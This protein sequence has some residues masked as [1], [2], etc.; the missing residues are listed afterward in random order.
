MRSFNVSKRNSSLP[1]SLLQKV[2]MNFPAHIPLRVVLVVPFVLQTVT[3][4]A[5]TGYFSYRNG[6]DAIDQLAHQFTT[7]LSDRVDQHLDSYLGTAKQVNQV[8][9]NALQNGILDPHDFQKLGQHFWNQTQTY[10]LSSIRFTQLSQAFVEAADGKNGVTIVEK[11][12]LTTLSS[13]GNDE[14]A[15]P[16]SI[17]PS[18]SPES[19]AQTQVWTSIQA[20]ENFPKQLNLAVTTPV[21]DRANQRIGVTSATVD[22]QEIN[23]FLKKLSTN[24]TGTIFIVERS[25][26]LVAA[27]SDEPTYKLAHGKPE[28]LPADASRD[29]LVE[30]TAEHLKTRFGTLQNIP[31]SQ[32]LDIKINGKRQFVQITPYQDELGLDWLLVVMVPESNFITTLEDNYRTTLLLSVLALVG[33]IALGCLTAHWIAKPILRLSRASRALALGDLD[34]PVEEDSLI[35][36]L[37]VLAH[38]FNQMTEHLQQSFDQV[39]IALQESEERFTK[40]FRTS[41]DAITVMS[42]AEG[43]YLEVNDRFLDCTGYRRD[44]VIGRSVWELNLLVNLEQAVALQQRLKTHKAFRNLELSYRTKSAQLRT[45]LLSAEVIEL[46]GQPCLLTVFLDITDRKQ[47]EIALQQSQAKLDSILNSAG[48]AIVSFR[49]SPQREWEYEYFSAGCEA[50]YGYTRQELMAD[51]TLWWSRIL[52]DDQQLIIS[53]AWEAIFAERSTELEYRFHHPDGLMR[54]IAASWT[55]RWNSA[56]GRWVVTTVDRD[57]T[58]RKQAEENLRRSEA[59]LRKAQQVAHVGCWEYDLNTPKQTWSEELFRI[60][61]LDPAVLEPSIDQVLEKIIHPDDRAMYAH[62]IQQVLTQQQSFEIDLRIMRPD[63]SMRFVE[64]RGEPVLDAR[65]QASRYVGTVLD[66]TD[67]KLA[68]DTLR[69]REQQLRQITDAL[70]ACIAYLDTHHCYQFTNKS[71]EVQFGWSQNYLLGKHI[72]EVIGDATYASLQFHLDYALSG[73]ITTYTFEQPDRN[74]NLRVYEVTLV[75]DLTEAGQVRGCHSL[76]IDITA[77]RYTEDAFWRSEARFRGLFDTA[78]IGMGIL[79][80]DGQ[81]L[82]V[83]ASACQM[84]GYTEAELLA[85]TLQQLS[86]PA[87][88]KANLE[89]LQQVLSGELSNSHLENRFL[90]RDGYVIW[91]LLSVALVRDPLLNPLYLVLQIQDIS[92][93]QRSKTVLRD[94]ESRLHKLAAVSPGVIYTFVQRPDGFVYFEYI[95]AACEELHEVTLQQVFADATVVL[96]QIHPDDRFAYEAAVYQSIATL[97]AF[98]HEWRIITPSGKLK[99][100]K[101]NSRPQWRDNGEIVWHGV[102]IDVTDSKQS[103]LEQMGSTD[104]MV[105]DVEYSAFPGLPIQRY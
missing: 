30:A 12:M 89:S 1:K 103:G 25:G 92:L 32:R 15:L 46:E 41:P 43:R 47:L 2:G 95:S 35:H 102:V 49:M 3:A 101:A 66:I 50:L 54:W 33:T 100:L 52:A 80:P 27:S 73:Q 71:Y 59:K 23:P 74:G 20:G 87:D 13:L 85:M 70:P 94:G 16:Y 28:R 82:E 83:N 77:H 31:T 37:E 8:N 56:L 67:R 48:S 105:K 11:P 24:K 69:C 42:L 81:F 26:L 72:R 61:G 18:N 76:V 5:L 40:V 57:I 60:C 84:F 99:W 55:S 22:L 93:T 4:V 10:E 86:H 88:S 38:S 62:M 63:G 51:K 39:K 91:G 29:V 68:E 34:Q 9:A 45:G 97:A 58:A 90:H 44:E 14:G 64:L 96:H 79:A 17:A 19:V 21:Y 36:E 98:T 65:R 104:R 78:T 75:P 6:Q 7:E 53:T